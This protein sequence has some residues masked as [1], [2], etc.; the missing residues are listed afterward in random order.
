[1]ANDRGVHNKRKR[2]EET[3]AL[4]VVSRFFK[5]GD[6]YEIRDPKLSSQNRQAL[7]GGDRC[8]P[9]GQAPVLQFY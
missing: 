2:L 1:M 3:A 5:I 7:L 8:L 9:D 6:V 4:G